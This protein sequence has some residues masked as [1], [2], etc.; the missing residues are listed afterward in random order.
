[1]IPLAD[2]QALLGNAT[3]ADAEMALAAAVALVENYLGRYLIKKERVETLDGRPFMSTI[4]LRAFPIESVKV[5]VE[6]V[7]AE[8]IAIDRRCGILSFAKPLPVGRQNIEVTYI[9]G[10]S[11]DD[12]PADI[13]MALRFLI[14][15]NAEMEKESG[16]AVASKR[17]GDYQVRY[18]RS[19]ASGGAAGS[20]AGG[21]MFYA[22]AV[23]ALLRPYMVYVL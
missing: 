8:P 2:I 11:E 17:I 9:G 23:A 12:L 7:E 21:L 16:K 10:Y 15:K 22:P 1:M 6:G 14:K 13:R 20:P 19:A 4:R 18:E 3:E 5:K